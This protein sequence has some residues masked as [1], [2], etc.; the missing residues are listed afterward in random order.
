MFSIIG[1]RQ[2]NYEI[3]KKF[4]D[5]VYWM[6]EHRELF[7]D[8][9]TMNLPYAPPGWLQN[10]SNP[11]SLTHL[12]WLA[13]TVKNWSWEEGRLY[14]TNFPDIFWIIR[15]GEGD[16]EWGKNSG[17]FK[18]RFLTKLTIKAEKISHIDDYF[19]NFLLYQA[20]GIELPLFDYTGPDPETFKE[21]PAVPDLTNDP[22]A[23]E[24]NAKRALDTFVN[25]E[26]W[27]E[28]QYPVYSQNFAHELPFTPEN[29]PRRYV[30]R[31]YDALNE[32]LQEHTKTWI[33]HDG[34]VLYE[35][36]IE[37]E[38]VI[39]SAGNGHMTWSNSGGATYQNRHISWLKIVDGYATDYYEYFNPV[40]KFNSI[41]VSIP[42]IP[43]LQGWMPDFS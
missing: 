5:S 16:L 2:T 21:W 8:D 31:E 3:A 15:E 39:E 36:D 32:W 41:G 9:F 10:M 11:E 17:H 42:T 33:V 6:P 25:V 13:A 12:N 29:M 28:E 14:A 43:Y 4:R 23:L 7:A 40:C 27:E 38:Y 19:D 1:L 35:T 24:A 18:S 37:G 22:E 26:F 30:G 20:L 34:T